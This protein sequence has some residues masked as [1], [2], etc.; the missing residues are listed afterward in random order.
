MPPVPARRVSFS[1]APTTPSS[2]RTSPRASAKSLD[3]D[4]S[5]TA[6]GSSVGKP[7]LRASTSKPPVPLELRTH[8]DPL[9]R[10]LRLRDA[11]GQPASLKKVLG[12]ASVVGFFF[13]TAQFRGKVRYEAGAVALLCVATDARLAQLK[14]AWPELTLL[15]PADFAKDLERFC[16]RNPHRFKAIYVSVDADKASADA[17][18]ANKPY[19]SMECVR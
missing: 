12:E 7:A 4:M 16:R 1:A 17:M 18:T 9:L 10:R 8:P 15:Q 2:P 6:S 5:R 14:L 13:G 3:A 19:L 11:H